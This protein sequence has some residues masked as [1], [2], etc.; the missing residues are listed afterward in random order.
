M[1]GLRTLRIFALITFSLGC[2]SFDDAFRDCNIST[3]T[4]TWRIQYTETSGDCGP[5]SD[6]TMTYS[7]GVSAIAAECSTTASMSSDDVCRAQGTS[8]C[9]TADDLG[10]QH[11]T[12]SL[13]QTAADQVEG[14]G[15][16]QVTHP[17]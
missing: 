15:A 10:V 1:G 16:V 5:L 9:P 3:I 8:D 6:E 7:G 12:W 11:W 14:S 2:D 13:K 17:T 4:G